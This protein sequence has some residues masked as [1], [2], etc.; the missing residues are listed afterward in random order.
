MQF[1]QHLRVD[2]AL[3]MP[4]F[5]ALCNLHVHQP[6]SEGHSVNA[7]LRIVE[8]EPRKMLR[9]PPAITHAHYPG[10]SMF[11]RMHFVPIRNVCSYSRR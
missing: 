1:A 11:E 8:E 7:T 3:F 9:Q 4:P 6:T 5:K 10:Q 2:L